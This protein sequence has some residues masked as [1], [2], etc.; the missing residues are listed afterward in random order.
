MPY[1][2]HLKVGVKDD[3]RSDSGGL[4]MLVTK[5]GSRL[6]RYAYNFDSKQKLLAL[7]RYRVSLPSFLSP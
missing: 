5:T 1:F 6:W 2:R 7:A 3:N 4:F